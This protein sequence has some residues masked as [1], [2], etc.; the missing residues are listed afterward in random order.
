MGNN[1]ILERV[2]LNFSILLLN[3]KTSTPSYMIYGELERYPIEI[4]V[5]VRI[6]S[7]W[8]KLCCGKESKL[9]AIIYKLCYQM[10]V[11]DRCTFLWLN[12]ISNKIILNECGMSN[13]WNT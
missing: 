4:D 9:S 7:F 6:I 12:E 2:H 8:T 3:L 10:S 1:D 13:I 5:N 11:V